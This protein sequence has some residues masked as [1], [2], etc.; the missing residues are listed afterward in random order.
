MKRKL[1]AALLSSSLLLLMP[2]LLL[3]AAASGEDARELRA[4]I[5]A[6]YP[7]AESLYFDL[8][9]HPELSLHEQRTA[10]T[11]AAALRDLGYA[12]TEQVGHTGVVGVMKNGQGPVVLLRT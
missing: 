9:R 3:A 5:D 1:F 7:Q 10:A 2:P 8:H 11:L 6:V 4:E 12:V